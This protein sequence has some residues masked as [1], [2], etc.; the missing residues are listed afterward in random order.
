MELDYNTFTNNGESF[1]AIRAAQA[2]H[3]DRKRIFHKELEIEFESGVGV[4]A[5]TDPEAILEWSDDGGHTW[6]SEHTATFGKLGEFSKRAIW[7]R[8]GNSRGRVYRVTIDDPVKR[9]IIGAHLEF[10]VGRL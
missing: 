1:K 8:L 10:E 6:S 7:R 3:G 4:D 2:I 9:I 5:D